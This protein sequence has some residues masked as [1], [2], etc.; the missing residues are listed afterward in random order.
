MDEPTPNG[1]AEALE[2]RTATPQTAATET[3][4]A[5]ADAS[6]ARGSG[7]IGKVVAVAPERANNEDSVMALLPEAK[8]ERVAAMRR[9]LADLQR[10][11]IDAQQRIA[12]ELQGRAEDAERFEALEVKAQ[13]SATRI[14]ELE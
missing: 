14:T 2:Q 7:H 3:D 4:A 1:F 9:E 8:A 5:P 12:T 11:L 10:Q 6:L 13:Q